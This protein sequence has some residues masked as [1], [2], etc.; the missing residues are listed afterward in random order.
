MNAI[1]SKYFSLISLIL[2]T[3]LVFFCFSG[4]ISFA[5]VGDITISTPD[6]D[7]ENGS[8]FTSEVKVDVDD[9]VLGS[10]DFTVN[11]DKDIPLDEVVLISNF[12]LVK[13][14][15]KIKIFIL[16]NMLVF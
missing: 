12:K 5:A 10:Y 8:T 16:F 9:T 2:I 15:V 14:L 7:P 13:K 1:K 4:G 6:S 3:A 11:F